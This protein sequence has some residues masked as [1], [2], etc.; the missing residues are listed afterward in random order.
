M[1]KRNVDPGEAQDLDDLMKAHHEAQEQVAEEMLSLTKTLKE[2][3][4]AAK[5]VI[6]KDTGVIEKASEV[7]DKNA[8]RLKKETERIEEHTKFSCRYGICSFM[9]YE[10]PKLVHFFKIRQ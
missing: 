1:R 8:E 2:Q 3:T 9:R 10:R 5:E 4:L 6:S 7:T